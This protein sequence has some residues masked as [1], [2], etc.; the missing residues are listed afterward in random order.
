MKACNI[1]LDTNVLIYQT[2]D[3]FDV[4]KHTLVTT[5]QQQLHAQHHTLWI[6]SQI[7]REFIAVATNGKIFQ[8]PL[9]GDDVIVKVEEFQANF[10]VLFDTEKSLRVLKE[11]VRQH[12]IIKAHIHDAN[13]A[14]TVIANKLD[15]LWTFNEKDFTPFSR[16]QLFD[17]ASPLL[18]E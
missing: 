5:T 11:L 16:V 14:A 18:A 17:Y 4:E 6:S 13:I 9:Q 8:T 3:D 12:R 7:I 1:F 2:F 10:H 15:Y